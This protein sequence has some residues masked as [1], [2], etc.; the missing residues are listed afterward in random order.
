M[1]MLRKLEQISLARIIWEVLRKC[2]G[3][4]NRLVHQE[5]FDLLARIN[6]GNPYP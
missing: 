1:K 5:F 4:H 2:E 3:E 6:K